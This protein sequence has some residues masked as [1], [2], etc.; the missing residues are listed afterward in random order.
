MTIIQAQ[1]IIGKPLIEKEIWFNVAGVK[2]PGD[3]PAT[4]VAHGLDSAWQFANAITNNQESVS[5]RIRTPSDIDR[6]FAPIGFIGWSSNG[7]SPGNCKWQVEYIWSAIDSPTD[8]A[9]QE[10]LAGTSTA[11]ATSRGLVIAEVDGI[12]IPGADDEC[13]TFRITR[14]SGDAEDTIAGTVEM[15]GASLRYTSTD[16]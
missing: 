6:N 7:V 12:D 4:V 16:T 10:T 9:A 14:L 1:P 15:I 13:L 3:N 5:G 11:S 8:A 2:A